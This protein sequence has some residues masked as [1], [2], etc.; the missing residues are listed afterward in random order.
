MEESSTTPGTVL[1]AQMEEAIRSL[2][3][4]EDSL[5]AQLFSAPELRSF[6]T[7]PRENRYSQK[8]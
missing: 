4:M 2:R 7:S 8:M 1:T 5:L 6:R 3:E